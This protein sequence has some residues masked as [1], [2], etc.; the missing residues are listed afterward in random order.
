MI[1]PCGGVGLKTGGEERT[2]RAVLQC[3]AGADQDAQVRGG[4]DWRTPGAGPVGAGTGQTIQ[5]IQ[6]NS[7]LRMPVR[8][9][10][11]CRNRVRTIGTPSVRPGR[12]YIVQWAGRQARSSSVCT[13]Q[14][15]Q[16]A[17]QELFVFEDW[18]ESSTWILAGCQRIDAGSQCRGPADRTNWL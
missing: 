12:T 7:A 9:P 4:S 3:L 1:G 13:V 10:F 8:T 15:T 2:L 5:A 14:Y 16:H 18:A 11:S 6:G 17:W